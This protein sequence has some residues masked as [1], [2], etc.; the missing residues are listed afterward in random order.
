MKRVEISGFLP[1]E[2][3]GGSLLHTTIVVAV[4]WSLFIDYVRKT[5]RNSVIM[6]Y[7]AEN[8]YDCVAQKFASLTD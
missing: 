3:H 6:L 8:F 1:H 5:G 4:N 7:D 2:Q